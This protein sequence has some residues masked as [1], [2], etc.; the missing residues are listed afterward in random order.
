MDCQNGYNNCK[1]NVSVH[2]RR[3]SSK[4]KGLS[5]IQPNIRVGINNLQN[6]KF[7]VRFSLSS[8]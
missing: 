6:D 7:N 3:S 5:L 4:G 8:I 1:T 2:E